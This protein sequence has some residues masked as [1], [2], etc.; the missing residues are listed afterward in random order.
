[1]SASE[2]DD[3]P[4]YEDTYQVI[5]REGGGNAGDADASTGRLLRAGVEARARAALGYGVEHGEGEGE[6]EGQSEV[7]RELPT[8]AP[9][10]YDS[11]S[12]FG[13]R[14]G[15]APATRAAPSASTPASGSSAG[16]NASASGS[17]SVGDGR[18]NSI[19]RKFSLIP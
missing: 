16:R 3:V 11:L 5:G 7:G 8:D 9:P 2:L 14:Q 15:P 19:R 17:S 13:R 12:G 10:D 18:R 1:M 6:G 4:E